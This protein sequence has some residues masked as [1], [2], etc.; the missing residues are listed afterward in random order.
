MWIIFTISICSIFSWRSFAHKNRTMVGLGQTVLPGFHLILMNDNGSPM[1]GAVSCTDEQVSEWYR[2]SWLGSSLLS[3]EGATSLH[4]QIVLIQGCWQLPGVSLM[5]WTLFHFWWALIGANHVTS[6]EV[7]LMKS[8]WGLWTCL[9]SRCTPYCQSGGIDEKTA[10][11]ILV[12][13]WYWLLSK[14]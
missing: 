4:K 3:H 10:N 13:S 14:L 5:L 1:S 12:F 11:N 7:F 9:L 8:S 6:L 2:Y